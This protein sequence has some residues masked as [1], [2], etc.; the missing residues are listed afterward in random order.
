M[1]T[2]SDGSGIYTLGRQPGTVLAENVIHDIPPNAGRAQ[3]NGI[4][5]DEGST[6]IR[7]EDNTIY[8]IARSPIRFNMAGTTRLS[9]TVWQRRLVSRR[10][11]VDAHQCKNG[12]RRQPANYQRCVAAARDDPAVSGG[13]RS[14]TLAP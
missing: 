4:F 9:Q 10:S 14:G 13:L 2:L 11:A 12:R 3:S 6:D 5:M 8:H 7:V 1:Q